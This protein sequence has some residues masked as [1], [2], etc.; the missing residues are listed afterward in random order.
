MDKLV[1]VYTEEQNYNSNA[2]LHINNVG[3]S[4]IHD[5]NYR[6][7][8]PQG[9]L[10]YQ[11]IYIYDGA[12]EFL[13]NDKRYQVGSGCYIILPPREKQSYNYLKSQ[14]H[15]SYWIHFSGQ[16]TEE[17]LND[18]QF[19]TQIPVKIGKNDSIRKCFHDMVNEML[20]QAPGYQNTCNYLLLK[21]F[22]CIKKAIIEQTESSKYISLLAPALLEMN[23]NNAATTNLQ[24]Y[25]NLCNLSKFAFAHSF[26]VAMGCSP[27]KY[28]LNIKFNKAKDL[29][30]N[31]DFSINEIALLLGFSSPLYFSQQFKKNIGI[32]PSQYRKTNASF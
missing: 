15:E 10:D 19:E 30:I 21:I 13:I 18:L 1:S 28:L 4:L 17:I 25:A 14:Q 32:S 5:K 27:I 16:C 11:L 22:S 29:L 2:Y 8:R 9:R 23:N 31:S 7:Y 24:H 20:L 12:A 3:Y 6:N 26:T